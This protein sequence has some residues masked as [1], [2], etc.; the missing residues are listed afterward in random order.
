MRKALAEED[1]WTEQACAGGVE[2]ES[3]MHELDDGTQVA[4][5]VSCAV[6]HNVDPT[7]N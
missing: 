4:T 2:V 6:T 3:Q 7:E 5:E 1:Q